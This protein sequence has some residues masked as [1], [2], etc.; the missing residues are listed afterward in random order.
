MAFTNRQVGPRASEGQPASSLRLPRC[1]IPPAV[2]LT[3]FAS[4]GFPSCPLWPAHS[5]AGSALALAAASSPT[6]SPMRSLARQVQPPSRPTITARDSVA[7][8]RWTSSTGIV[9]P[10]RSDERNNARQ[11]A[12]RQLRYNDNRGTAAKRQPL[13]RA[14][15]SR[16]PA[17]A[18][19]AELG[20]IRT[21]LSVTRAFGPSAPAPAGSSR[22]NHAAGRPVQT[23]AALG[24]RELSV[25]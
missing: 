14:H 25:M 18:T 11:T 3:D 8:L 13:S 4:G 16:E 20:G 15:R 5:R 19:R 10:P 9:I 2:A 21:S 12:C 1:P 7:D 6:G 17:D 22:S 23:E 24:Q